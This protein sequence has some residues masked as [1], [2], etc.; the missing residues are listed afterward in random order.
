MF[1]CLKVLVDHFNL[2][3]F[4]LLWCIGAQPT[5]RSCHLQLFPKFGVWFACVLL[6]CPTKKITLNTIL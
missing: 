1:L 4:K 6:L 3:P 5:G 2:N